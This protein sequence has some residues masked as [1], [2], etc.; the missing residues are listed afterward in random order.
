[1]IAPVRMA[2]IAIAAAVGLDL[3]E[4]APPGVVAAPL[5]VAAALHPRLGRSPLPWGAATLLGAFALARAPLAVA[6]HHHLATWLALAVTLAALARDDPAPPL[7]ESA[8]WLFAGVMG[9]AALHKL[10]SPDY[11]DGSFLGFLIARGGL[12]EPILV[13][14]DQPASL[15]GTNA[16]AVDSFLAAPPTPGGTLALAP[17]FGHAELA[18]IART[19]SWAI[20]VVEAAF[21]VAA[22]L[23]PRSPWL[24][25]ALLAFLAAL[26]V[27][28]RELVFLSLL[29]ALG[30]AMLATTPSRLRWAY[31]AL[32]VAVAPFALRRQHDLAEREVGLHA[33]VRLRDRAEGHHAVDHRA[34]RAARQERP[35]LRRE[36]LRRGD[37]LLERAA[38]QHRPHDGQAVA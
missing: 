25:G 7:A 17:P 6:N 21:A 34:H 18:V 24:H 37:L 12:L 23:R 30:L 20:V 8:R 28:R 13:H 16:A 2:V 22:A 27:T 9:F 14:L 38:A 35:H 33:P 36:R 3:V 32:V 4:H 15:L 1:V 31:L 26:A 10:L 19:A 29:A 11:R 5:L